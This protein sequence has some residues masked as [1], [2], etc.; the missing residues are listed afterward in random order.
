MATLHACAEK[1]D[2]QG[3]LRHLKA[4]ANVNAFD[5]RGYTPLYLAMYRG[6]C[7]PILLEY[8]ADPEMCV[9]GITAL[10]AACL[11]NMPCI[12]ALLKKA[13]IDAQCSSGCTAL[14][15]AVMFDQINVIELLLKHGANPNIQD[16]RGWTPLHRAVISEK[17]KII[18]LLLAHGA[19]S[20][21]DNEG[22]TPLHHAANGNDLTSAQLLLDHGVDI[23]AKDHSGET[24]RDIAFICYKD[25][26]RLIDVHRSKINKK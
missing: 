24:A 3:C 18:K 10:M 19:L 17:Y 1:D 12:P 9:T 7:V 5:S 8:G 25:I 2:V 15:W 23:D 22:Y 13:K 16:D 20:I 11:H 6:T 26:V 14:H 4:G 21:P